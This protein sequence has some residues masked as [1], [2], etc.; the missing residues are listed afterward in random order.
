LGLIRFSPRRFVDV[1]SR[2]LM[3]GRRKAKGRRQ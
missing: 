3:Q 2:Y 1:V